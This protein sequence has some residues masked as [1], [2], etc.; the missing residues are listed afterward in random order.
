MTYL[1]DLTEQ[2]VDPM[3]VR[4][5]TAKRAGGMEVGVSCRTY[6]PAAAVTVYRPEVTKRKESSCSFLPPLVVNSRRRP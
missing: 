4:P 6:R 3:D 2:K 5:R 1:R